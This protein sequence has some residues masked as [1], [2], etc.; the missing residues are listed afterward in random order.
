MDA[1]YT[2]DPRTKGE[3]AAGID[4]P[5]A[6]S[7]IVETKAARLGPL[8]RGLAPWMSRLAIVNGVQVNTANHH[9]GLLQAAR[10]RMN[11]A[12]WTP[13]A[14]EI[15]GAHRD[16][17]A[18]GYLSLNA[19]L[20]T[21]YTPSYF[22]EPF[23]GN[24]GPAA[25]SLFSLV[26]RA[27]PEELETVHRVM[28][29]HAAS[30][31]RSG[32]RSERD[33]AA[34]SAAEQSAAFFRGAATTPKFHAE[35][36]LPQA[37]EGFDGQAN[38]SGPLQRALWTFEHD[39]VATATVYSGLVWDSHT[40]NAQIQG[41]ATPYLVALLDRLFTELGT[42]R[43]AHGTLADQTAV[44]VISDLGRFPYLNQAQ[45]K[46]HF[47]QTSALFFGPSFHAGQ[48]G[49]TGKQLETLPVSL[50]TGHEGANAHQVAL[51]D[52]GTTALLLAG[53]DPEPHG[54]TGRRLEFLAGT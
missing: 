26:D 33:Q 36:W 12:R 35:S 6:A 25:T 15:I 17:Q 16:G 8:F 51:D 2:T 45:G 34:R 9:T 31:T 48:F 29:E 50:T 23:P 28:S 49:A 10:L 20:A 43:N 24:Y 27:S 41:A 13:S 30:M 22:G 18:V 40:R 37:M 53:I 46:D 7:E 14:L 52:I 21:A 32:R 3:V 38:L 19:P 11:T 1:V 4:V 47:P 39:L 42:R 5:Y 54:F 44:M